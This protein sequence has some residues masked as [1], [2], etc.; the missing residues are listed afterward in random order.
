[1]ECKRALNTLCLSEVLELLFGQ[2][3]VWESLDSDHITYPTKQ[4][5]NSQ[6]NETGLSLPLFK[7]KMNNYII[8]GL[9]VS[10][11]ESSDE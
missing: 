11:N 3:P 6:G 8:C 7:I 9:Y 10:I 1:V 5:Q 4:Y 2:R